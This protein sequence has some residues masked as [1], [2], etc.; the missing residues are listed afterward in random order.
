NICCSFTPLFFSLEKKKLYFFFIIAFCSNRLF[1]VQIDPRVLFE[2][3]LVISFFYL[4]Q[5]FSYSLFPS[6]QLTHS[7]FH[8]DSLSHLRIFEFVSLLMIIFNYQ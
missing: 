5:L 7:Y 2:Y 8:C 1:C 4:T 3:T 6:L